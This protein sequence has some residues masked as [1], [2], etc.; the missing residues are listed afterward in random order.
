LDVGA[1]REEAENNALALI[2]R[3][4]IPRLGL[5]VIPVN[6]SIRKQVTEGVITYT[7][8]FDT[9]CGNIFHDTLMESFTTS[10]TYP[11]DVFANVV[12]PGRQRGPLFFSANT[13]QV[14]KYTLNCEIVLKPEC[15]PGNSIKVDLLPENE[16]VAIINNQAH[17]IFDRRVNASL[18]RKIRATINGKRKCSAYAIMVARTHYNYIEQSLGKIIRIESDV[19]NWDA[20]EGRYSRNFT[21]VFGQCGGANLISLTQ[22]FRNS[23][24]GLMVNL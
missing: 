6:K 19:D 1:T 4:G 18:Q 2:E 23:D 17:S 13:Y 8:E 24:E 20:A 5:N 16:S 14:T 21:F 22:A 15:P 11:T 7:Y 12:I 10:I 3:E 9:K